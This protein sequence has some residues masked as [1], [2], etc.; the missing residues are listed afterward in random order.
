MPGNSLSRKGIRALRLARLRRRTLRVERRTGPGRGDGR[1]LG[2]RHR[3]GLAIVRGLV[4]AHA[5][6]VWIEDT[7]EGEGAHFAFTLPA[8]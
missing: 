4:E 7:E 5:G 3:S 2:E 6:R 1:A 8:A